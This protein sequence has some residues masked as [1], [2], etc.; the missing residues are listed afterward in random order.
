VKLDALMMSIAE[1]IT[2]DEKQN[3]KNERKMQVL[4]KLEAKI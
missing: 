4:H 2:K 3:K 1:I